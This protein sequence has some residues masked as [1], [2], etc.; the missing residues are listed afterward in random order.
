MKKRTLGLNGLNSH[1]KQISVCQISELQS[2]LRVCT[3][4]KADLTLKKVETAFLAL[5]Q[6]PGFRDIP[7]ASWQT[8]SQILNRCQRAPRTSINGTGKEKL[9]QKRFNCDRPDTKMYLGK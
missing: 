4:D 3:L 5:N 2:I 7:E 1:M 9:F 8:Q 6:C